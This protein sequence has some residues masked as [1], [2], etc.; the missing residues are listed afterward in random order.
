MSML[1][2]QNYEV[3]S[4]KYE[5]IIEVVPIITNLVLSYL[6]LAQRPFPDET[7]QL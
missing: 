5:V 2:T 4:A 7:Y 3:I 1:G 6:T